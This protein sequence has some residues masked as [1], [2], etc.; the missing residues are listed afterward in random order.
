MVG[1]MSKRQT[2]G[3]RG[4]AAARQFAMSFDGRRLRI[5]RDGSGEVTWALLPPEGNGDGAL[6]T[7]FCDAGFVQ[8]LIR[9][10]A[11]VQAMLEL[12]QEED[13]G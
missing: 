12:V 11:A 9:A 1:E 10:G 7:G 2:E 4:G 6:L 5:T 8:E 3:L 13:A